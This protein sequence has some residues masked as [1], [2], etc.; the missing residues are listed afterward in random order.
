MKLMCAIVL[1][2]IA[3]LIAARAQAADLVVLIGWDGADY[4]LVSQMVEAGELPHLADVV[5]TGTLQ[6][7]TIEERTMTKPSW[8]TML[9]GLPWWAHGTESNL[10]YQAIPPNKTIFER[11]R[12]LGIPSAYVTQK[13]QPGNHGNLCGGSTQASD[14]TMV[15]NT[16][17]A[18]PEATVYYSATQSRRDDDYREFIP[19]Q[20]KRCRKGIKAVQQAS[21]DGRGFVWCHYGWPDDAGHAFGGA[22]EEYRDS[23]RLLDAQIPTL[24]IGLPAGAVVLVTSDHGFERAGDPTEQAVTN[25][26]RD[27]G[28]FGLTHWYEPR[29]ILGSAV[30]LLSPASGRDV[31]KTLLVLLKVETPAY[32]SGRSLVP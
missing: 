4:R 17:A 8:A 14:G 13:C 1:L 32:P 27:V 29:A 2:A 11:L 7:L 16:F 5:S 18:V 24:L 25:R 9:S 28:P 12:A 26:Y 10:V 20:T 3:S 19:P 22:S 23:L 6:Q 31:F 21:R 15:P 30:P